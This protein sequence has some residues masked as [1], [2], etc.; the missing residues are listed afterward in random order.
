[1]KCRASV[2]ITVKDYMKC[3]N[4]NRLYGEGSRLLQ[5]LVVDN[6]IVQKEN[7]IK[8]P[9]SEQDSGQECRTN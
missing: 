5:E 4:V 1:M 2:E 7:L 3:T 9:Y 8:L 6:E